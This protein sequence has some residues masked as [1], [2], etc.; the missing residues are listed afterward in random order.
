MIKVLGNN[1]YECLVNS[2]FISLSNYKLTRSLI[3]EIKEIY[4]NNRL[5]RKITNISLFKKPKRL[6]SE[7]EKMMEIYSRILRIRRKLGLY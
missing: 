3:W 6:D 4:K 5:I 1:K 7:A 2:L